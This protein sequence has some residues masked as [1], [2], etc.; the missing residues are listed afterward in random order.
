[1]NHIFTQILLEVSTTS[2]SFFNDKSS[3]PSPQMLVLEI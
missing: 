1:M 3:I 2:K